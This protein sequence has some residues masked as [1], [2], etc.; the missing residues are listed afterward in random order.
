M[1][2]VR[3]LF[4]RLGLIAAITTALLLVMMALPAMAAEAEPTEPSV[5]NIKCF[6]GELICSWLPI[7]ATP[8]SRYTLEAGDQIIEG[9]CGWTGSCTRIVFTDVD[10]IATGGYD[11]DASTYKDAPIDFPYDP[12]ELQTF[13]MV[14]STTG[15]TVS[16]ELV[17]PIANSISWP[18]QLKLSLACSN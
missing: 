2:S 5:P 17:T 13:E 11:K 12:V 16:Y 15:I 1:T 9:D 18:W 14:T 3:Y 8:P 7:G 6:L 4:I 10:C